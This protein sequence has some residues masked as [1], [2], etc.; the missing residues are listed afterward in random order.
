MNYS[1]NFQQRQ[2][3]YIDL[4]LTDDELLV[5]FK[6]A[7]NQDITF[8]QLVNNIVRAVIKDLKQSQEYCIINT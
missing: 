2:I 1:L 4:E 3:M 7:H 8:N 5:L 6:E